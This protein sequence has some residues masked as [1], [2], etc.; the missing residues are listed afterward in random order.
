MKERHIAHSIV[1]A[2]GVKKEIIPLDAL[3]IEGEALV[4][5]EDSVPNIDFKKIRVK[6][7]NFEGGVRKTPYSPLSTLYIIDSNDE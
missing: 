7:L 1:K 4:E 3:L 6:D 2:T 5:P